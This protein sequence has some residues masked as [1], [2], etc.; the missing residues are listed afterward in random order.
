MV[1]WRKGVA[2]ASET[3]DTSS[4]PDGLPGVLWTKQIN[5]VV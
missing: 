5:A 4:N 2:S 3:E 1:V